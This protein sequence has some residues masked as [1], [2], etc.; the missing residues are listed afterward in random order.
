MRIASDG[1]PARAPAPRPM[2]DAEEIAMLKRQAAAARARAAQEARQRQETEAAQNTQRTRKNAEGAV[3]DYNGKVRNHQ[4]GWVNRNRGKYKTQA[5]AQAAWQTEWENS[6]EGKEAKRVLLPYLAEYSGAVQHE[7]R[8]SAT[9]TGS[10]SAAAGTAIDGKVAEIRGRDGGDKFIDGVLD[11][12]VTS[13]GEMVKLESPELRDAAIATNGALG[14]RD[15]AAVNLQNVLDRRD[16]ALSGMRNMGLRQEIRDSFQ[17]ELEAAQRELGL[18]EGEL[19][20]ALHTEF[21]IDVADREVRGAQGYLDSLTGKPGQMQERVYAAGDLSRAQQQRQD[22]LAGKIDLTIASDVNVDAALQGVFSRHPELAQEANLPFAQELW[23]QAQ[24]AKMRPELQAAIDQ[25]PMIANDPATAQWMKDFIN[26]TNDPVSAGMIVVLGMHTAEAK[27]DAEKRLAAE[28][29]VTFAFLKYLGVTFDMPKSDLANIQPM[30]LMTAAQKSFSDRFTE[31][32]K[33]EMPTGP[34]ETWTPEQKADVANLEKLQT[35]QFLMVAAGPARTTFLEQQWEAV[36]QMESPEQSLDEILE[37]YLDEPDF[38]NADYEPT[39]ELGKFMKTLHANMQACFTPEQQAQIWD[40]IGVDVTIYLGKQADILKR[41]LDKADDGDRPGVIAAI[42]EWQKQIGQFAVPQVANVVIDAT[43]ARFDPTLIGQHG[44]GRMTDGLQILADRAGM[45]G[46]DKLADWLTDVSDKDKYSVPLRDLMTVRK[47]GTGTTLGQSLLHEMAVDG[48]DQYA[49]QDARSYYEG[50]LK[51]AQEANIEEFLS[52]QF[53]V[54]NENRSQKLQDIFDGA[55][56]DNGDVFTQKMKFGTDAASDNKYGAMLGL[57][58]DVENAADGEAKYT[59]PEKLKKIHDLKQIDWISRGANI[60]IDLQSIIPLIAEGKPLPES[61]ALKQIRE[62]QRLV[63]E[64]GGA[65]AEVSFIPAVY[66]SEKVGAKAIYLM[67]VEGDGNNDGT[68]T[69]DETPQYDEYGNQIAPLEDEDII[70]DPSAM[71]AKVRGNNV[72]WKFNDFKDFQT[73][74][75]L[76]DDGKLY[77]SGSP[78]FLLHDR[79]GDRKVDDINF[80]GVDAAITTTWEN[81]RRWGDVVIGVTAM[82]AGVALI[83]GTGGLAAPLVALGA[84]AYFG[85]RTAETA[86]EMDDHGQSFNLINTR[87]DGA[88]FGFIDPAAGS[89][90]LG[91]AATV[92]G[93]GALRPLALGRSLLN[94]TRTGTFA[95]TTEE[96]AKFSRN[97]GTELFLKRGFQTTIYRSQLASGSRT[98]A[99]TAEITGGAVTLGQGQDFAHALANG[100]IDFTD[101]SLHSSTWDY[102]MMGGGIATYGGGH[103]ANAAR[104]AGVTAPPG[105]RPRI[106]EGQDLSGNGSGPKMQPLVVPGSESVHSGG[107][108]VVPGSEAAYSGALVIPGSESAHSGGPLVVPGSESAHNGGPIVVPRSRNPGNGGP[109]VI[110]VLARGRP[111]TKPIVSD[112]GNNGAPGTGFRPVVQDGDPFLPAGINRGPRPLT[113]DGDGGNLVWHTDN[114]LRDAYGGW[115]GGIDPAALSV[116]LL[117][118]SEFTASYREA[119]GREPNPALQGFVHPITELVILKSNMGDPAGTLHSLL[120]GHELL[121]KYQSPYFEGYATLLTLAGRGDGHSLSEGATEY[122]AFKQFG[123]EEFRNKPGGYAEYVTSLR[124]GGDGR[125]KL[126]FVDET[127]AIEKIADAMGL[128]RFSDAYFKGE[129]AA[130]NE[131]LDRAA[132]VDDR[133]ILLGHRNANGTALRIEDPDGSDQIV[134]GGPARRT[135]AAT[136]GINLSVTSSDG[137]FLPVGDG[138]VLSG[139]SSSPWQRPELVTSTRKRMTPVEIV[140]LL[141]QMSRTSGVSWR[142]ADFIVLEVDYGSMARGDRSMHPLTDLLGRETTI[143]QMLATLTGKPVVS[144]LRRPGDPMTADNWAITQPGTESPLV[145]KPHY[146]GGSLDHITVEGMRT[147]TRSPR[148]ELGHVLDASDV[149]ITLAMGRDLQVEIF[150][151]G[152]QAAQD[153][154][155]LRYQQLRAEGAE[156]TTVLGEPAVV[157][158]RDQTVMQTQPLQQQ[159]QQH[160]QPRKGYVSVKVRNP[161]TGQEVEAL[162]PQRLLTGFQKLAG[163]PDQVLDAAHIRR[164]G[165]DLQ[166]LAQGRTPRLDLVDDNGTLYLMPIVAG[167]SGPVHPRSWVGQV[168]ENAFSG[169]RNNDLRLGIAAAQPQSGKSHFL[170]SDAQKMELIQNLSDAWFAALVGQRS[171]TSP[172]LLESD[173]AL[174]DALVRY[175]QDNEIVMREPDTTRR[176]GRRIDTETR[177]YHTSQ[178]IQDGNFSVAGVQRFLENLLSGSH[179]V[180]PRAVGDMGDLHAMFSAGPLAGE[181]RNMLAHS[182]HPHRFGVRFGDGLNYPKSVKTD[183]TPDTP[184]VINAMLIGKNQTDTFFQLESWPAV[185]RA[186]MAGRHREGF[187]VHRDTSWNISTYGASPFTEKTGTPLTHGHAIILE[188]TPAWAKTLQASAETFGQQVGKDMETNGSLLPTFRARVEQDVTTAANKYAPEVL[189]QAVDAVSRQ[190]ALKAVT[191]QSQSGGKT[192]QIIRANREAIAS[193]VA[194]GRP[195]AVYDTVL[196]TLGRLAGWRPGARRDRLDAAAMAVPEAAKKVAE[197]IRPAVLSEAQSVNPVTVLQFDIAETVAKVLP[198][199]ASRAAYQAALDAGKQ[200]VETTVAAYKTQ[201]P[202]ATPEELAQVGNTALARFDLHGEAIALVEQWSQP[203]ATLP[204]AISTPFDSAGLT[205][206]RTAAKNTVGGKVTTFAAKQAKAKANVVLTAEMLPLLKSMGD[207]AAA[208]V[209][210]R[211]GMTETQK[212]AADAAGDHGMRM[213]LWRARVRARRDVRKEVRRDL[214]TQAMAISEKAVENAFTWVISQSRAAKAGTPDSPRQIGKTYALKALTEAANFVRDAAIAVRADWEGTLG[215]PLNDHETQVLAGAEHIALR[216]VKANLTSGFTRTLRGAGRLAA[217]TPRY[218]LQYARQ[219]GSLN[220]VTKKVQGRRVSFMR[221]EFTHDWRHPITG[222]RFQASGVQRLTRKT[223]LKGARWVARQPDL[224]ELAQTTAENAIAAKIL[225]TIN[226]AL[227]T[228]SGTS[229]DIVIAE[230][231]LAIKN[232]G[233]RDIRKV[234]ADEAQIAVRSEVAKRLAEAVLERNFYPHPGGP[235]KLKPTERMIHWVMEPF[236]HSITYTRDSY[237]QLYDS[238]PVD[239]RIGLPKPEDL[240]QLKVDNVTLMLAEVPAGLE[241]IIADVHAHSMGYDRRAGNYFLQLLE[242]SGDTTRILFGSIP[243]YCGGDGHYSTATPAKGNLKKAYKLDERVARDWLELYTSKNEADRNLAA[244]ADLSITGV[245]FRD[246]QFHRIHTWRRQAFRNPVKYMTRLMLK[247]PGMFVAVGEITGIK[248]MVTRQIKGWDWNVGSGKFRNFLSFVA[249]TGQ[250]V[251][252]HND[253][254]DHGISAQRRPSAAKQEYEHLELLKFVFSRPEYRN[255]QIIFAHTGIGRLVRPNNT[256][257]ATDQTYT[258]KKWVWDPK[259]GEGRVDVLGSR[260]VVVSKHAPEHI[261]QLYKLFEDVPNARVD[262]SWNDVTQAYLDMMQVDPAAADAVVDFFLDHQDRII[263]GSDTVKPVN[264][265]HYNQALETGAPLIAAIAR[266]SR[267][268]GF[269][270]KDNAAYKILRGNYEDA[271]R[272]AET[273]VDRWTAQQLTEKHDALVGNGFGYKARKVQANLKLMQE[274]RIDLNQRRDRLAQDSIAHFDNWLAKLSPDWSPGVTGN[275]HPG[276]MPV[277]Y[278][279]LPHSVPLPKRGTATGVGTS[280]GG[281]NDSVLRRGGTAVVAGGAIYGVAEGGDWVVDHTGGLLE[282]TTGGGYVP[283]VDGSPFADI[284]NSLAFLLRGGTLIGRGLYTEK[285]RLAWES[286]FEQGV[287]TREGLD[288]YV[289]RLFNT[290]PHL[291]ITP[292][293]RANIAAIT[294]QFWVNYTYLRDKPIDAAAGWTE[295]QKFLA[296]HAKVGEYMITVSRESGLQESSLNALDARRPSGKFFRAATLG[297]YAFNNAIAWKWLQ[298]GGLDFNVFVDLVSN[299]SLASGQAASETAFRLLF[300]LGNAAL[301]T[302]EGVSLIGGMFKITGTET[303][304]FQKALQRW[305]MYGLT[306]GGAAWTASDAMILLEGLQNGDPVAMQ[307]ASTLLKAAFTWG[308]F[309]SAR[310]EFNRAHNRPMGGPLAQSKP[311]ILLG[312]ALVA[313]MIIAIGREAGN[314]P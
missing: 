31:I 3:G 56:K 119:H 116:L 167:G 184:P 47:D 295:Q 189:D 176:F 237:K 307:A 168:Q 133:V 247:Y 64:T 8:V 19:N 308:T 281:A 71:E 224:K 293:Q 222:N 294:E 36:E 197:T 105:F 20:K 48:A 267:A 221:A 104:R 97:I 81:V 39:S 11:D 313:A 279:R 215:R 124:N 45:E 90:W 95:R 235:T 63:I 43:T 40:R 283:T 282:P 169:T 257:R 253:W 13:S 67:R 254:G 52:N 148:Q 194:G 216:A 136:Y 269:T 243:Q 122:L 93:L 240:A 162:L 180:A 108:I 258:I 255:V 34:E 126:A 161:V 83:A 179:F 172:H 262:I 70:I 300:A 54:F 164:P 82:V 204:E 79:N 217:D 155:Q 80:E 51:Y 299:P 165:E 111:G 21:A 142:D 37:E 150:R 271:I 225:P 183:A 145:L 310:H 250:L 177:L 143:E 244:K 65:N 230:R 138:V 263:F 86:D 121:H 25:L 163:G 154:A 112:V 227:L 131:F 305:G 185:V 144:P 17:A 274:R 181:T 156:L 311:G 231:N 208:P 304:K 199:Y 109:A 285:L 88:W 87:A 7:L 288:R 229:K 174:I 141:D 85:F 120:V 201:H 212:L 73:D 137:S 129:R 84:T 107:P 207:T 2:T 205:T 287:V 18:A 10:D 24:A 158:K 38:N 280:G 42:G 175:V 213:M 118:D 14:K 195:G 77:M 110:P 277:L 309:H 214:E 135:K 297:T 306:G 68:I 4:D 62:L 236:S 249:K 147:V 59:D 98:V 219:D 1:G 203:G 256:T 220:H 157:T 186:G 291:G 191:S 233:R 312:G 196:N 276:V 27:T 303:N 298:E 100:Q 5:A 60:P 209:I 234:G 134:P 115:I 241:H 270:G 53:K 273:R 246:T 92:S 259:T 94:V 99:W 284:G 44:G 228:G 22:V 223:T 57:A 268:A 26:G 78:D 117:G 192:K 232:A 278:D 290:A 245:N 132:V 16:K 101:W 6:A 170:I 210:K 9:G 96:G 153:R 146:K 28:S 178:E 301:T 266:K 206:A 50:G 151:G 61:D 166:A 15:T 289:S 125:G 66:A 23:V 202:N 29:P 296:L 187:E 106:S 32:A 58:P 226:S 152:D 69:R 314:W 72:P 103:A 286:I 159:M 55:I 114:G 76:D 130:V 193:S 12:I 41:S 74:N 261:H 252:L 149:S 188:P 33:K 160:P 30:D 173:L 75:M 200:H 113:D 140:L 292:L 275:N 248:E 182:H 89:V 49:L 139:F 35:L 242:K 127:L 264:K 211:A 46:G 238:L 265:G 218:S 190:T 123:P 128:D 272:I 198:G 260:T 91:G 239:R 251:V 102:A 171:T 302:R